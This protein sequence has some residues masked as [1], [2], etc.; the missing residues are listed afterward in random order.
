MV[1]VRKLAAWMGLVEDGRYRTDDPVDHDAEG[2]ATNDV[3]VDEEPS[4]E[5]SKVAPI[6]RPA[7]LTPVEH[8]EVAD[9]SRIVSVR[10]RSYNEARVIG[11]NFRDG[12]PVI[13]NLSDMEDGE[14]KRLVDFAAGLIFGLRG[15]IE[16]VS[17]KVFLLCPHNL[18]VGPEDK[19]RIAS[20]GFFNQS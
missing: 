11:E 20:G 13:M 8:K 7:Q 5:I 10:P 2:E 17:S 14:D 4:Q 9:L 16:R 1:G 18:V 12:I 3:Y 15:N 6:R 19:E